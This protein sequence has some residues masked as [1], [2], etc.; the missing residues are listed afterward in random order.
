ML[1]TARARIDSKI[2]VS[3]CEGRGGEGHRERERERER[4]AQTAIE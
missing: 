4:G 3:V 1:H 2:G